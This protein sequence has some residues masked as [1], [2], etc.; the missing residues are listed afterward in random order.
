MTLAAAPADLRSV[1]RKKYAFYRGTD[2]DS[3]EGLSRTLETVAQL[4]IPGRFPD[5]YL[6]SIESM[7]R[8]SQ[9]R[10]VGDRRV[11]VQDEALADTLN[12]LE[13]THVGEERPLV[14]W[15]IFGRVLCEFL[16]SGSAEPA[17]GFHLADRIAEYAAQFRD[18]EGYFPRPMVLRGHYGPSTPL[19][20]IQQEVQAL[21]ERKTR[22]MEAQRRIIVLH[23]VG[24][25]FRAVNAAWVEA[26]ASLAPQLVDPLYQADPSTVDPDDQYGP[27]RTQGLGA[28]EIEESNRRLRGGV[29]EEISCDI[30]ALIA[31]A[32]ND[33]SLGLS[34]DEAVR[35]LLR[36]MQFTDLIG[37]VRE[38]AR[39]RS[40]NKIRFRSV[41]TPAYV[42]AMALLQFVKEPSSEVFRLLGE[43]ASNVIDRLH[44]LDVGALWDEVAHSQKLGNHLLTLA[45]CGPAPW[46]RHLHYG[47]WPLGYLAPVSGEDMSIEAREEL[48]DRALGDRYLAQHLDETVGAPWFRAASH[49]LCRTRAWA[50]DYY[51]D[52]DRQREY[53]EL[54]AEE[55]SWTTLSRLQRTFLDVTREKARQVL[56]FP[57]MEQ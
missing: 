7:E 5:V 34:L 41:V 40:R 51:S 36:F 14:G 37:V 46:E 33:D 25:A 18:D 57:N 27:L 24:H 3:K 8:R 44:A 12:F 9:I 15:A 19:E 4:R 30:Y 22:H 43:E 11:L 35:C 48:F 32:L 56:V 17:L 10:S 45:I 16:F 6:H 31:L 52:E 26:W 13:Q 39:Q 1:M 49:I 42:R 2:P 53:G 38:Q 23:E 50:N 21:V 28:E 54:A 55:E 47:Q 20:E 29:Y